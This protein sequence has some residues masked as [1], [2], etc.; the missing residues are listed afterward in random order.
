LWRALRTLKALQAEAAAPQAEP[1]RPQPEATPDPAPARS[2]E[3]PKEPETRG[4]PREA[5]ADAAS[6]ADAMADPATP[7]KAAPASD[8]TH[9]CAQDAHYHAPGRPDASPGTPIEPEGRG[10]PGETTSF[11]ALRAAARPASSAGACAGRHERAVN[12][13]GGRRPAVAVD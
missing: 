12:L 8:A 13:F 5:R 11:D 3:S 10:N 7:S 4:N 1:A 9:R 6:T 2:P